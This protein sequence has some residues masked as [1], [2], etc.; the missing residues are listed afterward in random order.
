MSNQNKTQTKGREIAPNLLYHVSPARNRAS[1]ARSGI[2]PLFSQGKAQACWYVSPD[3]LEW[4]LAH[5]SARHKVDVTQLD[6]YSVKTVK[7]GLVRANRYSGV[8]S[9]PCRAVPFARVS[10]VSLIGDDNE[11]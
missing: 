11:Y 4:A 1:I 3:R 8:F 7:L 5:C 10:A 2:E 9:S 6:V